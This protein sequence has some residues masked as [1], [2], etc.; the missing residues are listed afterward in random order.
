M[1][2]R[3]VSMDRTYDCKLDECCDEYKKQF[4]D[5]LKTMT[6]TKATSKKNPLYIAERNQSVY[7]FNAVKR[8]YPKATAWFEFP[9]GNRQH[10]DVLIFIPKN[11]ELDHK[12]VLLVES[13]NI[14]T[15]S[16]KVPDMIGDVRRIDLGKAQESEALKSKLKALFGDL[17]EISF[18]GVFLCDV[19]RTG[20]NHKEFAKKWEDADWMKQFIN[21]KINPEDESS[22]EEWLNSSTPKRLTHTIFDMRH[23]GEDIHYEQ[24][25]RYWPI[26]NANK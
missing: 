21:E 5:F 10:L 14:R 4:A 24:L 9:L 3:Y 6:I 19:Q 1:R 7:F 11:S 12:Q 26:R 13:K 8:V 22:V 15:L 17:S 23:D 25:I 2:E 16:V 20:K 18:Y